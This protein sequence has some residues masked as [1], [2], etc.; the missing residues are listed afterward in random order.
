MLS[1]FSHV[2]CVSLS[3]VSDSLQPHELPGSSVH[4][5]LAM[6]FSR[7]EYWRGL[8]FPSGDL[9]N[10]GIKPT[11]VSCIVKQVFTTSTTPI[12]MLLPKEKRAIINLFT[13]AWCYGLHGILP[14]SVCGSPNSGTSECDCVW[15][16]KEG[17]KLK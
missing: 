9:P 10:P 5:I 7:Q 15:I 14:N 17:I 16:S 8:P 11:S 13:S 1:H 3:V 12:F 6:E 4:G 2:S